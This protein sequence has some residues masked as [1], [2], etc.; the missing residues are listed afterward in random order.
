MAFAQAIQRAA[1]VTSNPTFRALFVTGLVTAA[2]KVVGFGRELTVAGTYGA[3]AILD[4]FLVAVILPNLLMNAVSSAIGSSLLPRL[5]ALRLSE[6]PAAEQL[7]QRRATF[8]T[9]VL[10]SGTSIACASLGPWLLPWLSP[11]F[12][13]EHR[14]LTQQML[15]AIVPYSVVAGTTQ[16]WAILAN[17]EGKFAVTAAS[18][19]IV[20]IVS[21]G[22]LI[23]ATGSLSPWPLVIGLTLGSLG[24]LALIAWTLRGTRYSIR[25]LPSRLTAFEHRCWPEVWPLSLGALLHTGTLMVDQA[26]ASLVGPGTISELNYGNRLVAVVAS[27][28]GLTVSRVAFP[29]FSKLAAEKRYEELGRCIRRF[30]G[31]ILVVSIPSMIVLSA[32]SGW[33]VDVTFTRG[34]FTTETATRVGL[35]Q[36]MFAFQLPFYLIG[37]LLVRAIAALGMNRL[38]LW[39]GAGSLFLNAG[40]N[41]LLAGPLGAPGLA[42]ATSIVYLGTCVGFAITIG[43]RIRSASA[44][45][46]AVTDAPFTRAA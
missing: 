30:S 42:L 9:I 23:A 25:P 14:Q 16:V 28:V 3:S 38:I 15:W 43:F 22:V 12:S 45:E 6:G 26:M 33:I 5:I 4:A 41:L 34:Q 32:A 46:V 19:G 24:D 29:Q 11:G 17:S 10:L 36:A 21:I 40:L 44:A 2:C 20:S 31:V 35:I 37:T 27:L 8:W 1:R 39:F 7:A 13:D 18:P